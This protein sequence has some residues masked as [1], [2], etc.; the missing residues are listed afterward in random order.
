MPVDYPDTET[1][2]TDSFADAR[3]WIHEGVGAI[4]V[5]PGGGM[6]LH[7]KGSEQGAEGC[8]AFFRHPLPDAIAIEYDIVIHSHGGL[9]INF[10]GLRGRNGENPFAPGS[11]LKPRTGI[12]A[13]YFDAAW[14]LQSFHVSFSRF[15]DDGIHTSTS[16]WR[17]NPGLLLVGHGTDAVQQIGRRY[18]IR[19]TKDLGH[20]QM[21]VDGAFA[22]ACIDRDS[23]RYPIPDHGWFGFRLIGS[24]VKAD[25]FD[26]R[27]ARVESKQKALKLAPAPG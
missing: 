18:R 27:V 4:A 8:M 6:Q 17:R 7:C 14:G 19:L 3:H 25:I 1:L 12:F 13:N 23:S 11:P 5:L 15:N 16:N 9:V 2:F 10:L 22:H 21:F 20:A 24:D 26:F